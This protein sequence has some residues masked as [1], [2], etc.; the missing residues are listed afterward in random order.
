MT[1]RAGCR[2]PRPR[3]NKVRPEGRNN[4]K[5]A[6][7]SGS[8]VAGA[9]VVVAAALAGCGV[10]LTPVRSMHGPQETALADAQTLEQRIQVPPDAPVLV[11]VSS[12]DVDVKAAVIED[13][14][15]EPAY[16]DAPNRRMGVETL[17]VDAPHAPVVMVRIAR[18]DHSGARG[19]ITIEAVGLPLATDADRKRLAAARHD[20]DACR[21]FADLAQGEQAA[22]AYAEAAQSWGE[23]GDD[24]RQGFALLHASGARYQRQSDWS[25]SADLA[26]RAFARLESTES[27]AHAAFALR[28]QGAALDQLANAANYDVGRRERTAGRARELLSQAAARFEEL[29][30]TF[31]AGYALSYRGVSHGQAGDLPRS[32][33]DFRAAAERFRIAGDDPAQAVALQSLASLS[34][35]DGRSA[36]SVREFEA[37][38]ALIPRDED[39]ANYAHTLHNSAL[40]LRVLGRF[41]EAV[42][43]EHES[44]EMLRRLGDRDG[45]ARALHSLALV[46]MYTGESERAAELLR[47]AIR[48]RGETGVRREQAIALTNLAEI[49]RSSGR[50]EAALELD[51]QALELA[52]APHDRAR[53]LLS[54]A[55]DH[56]MSGARK[57]ARERL[58]SILGL[59]IAAAHRLRALALAELGSLEAQ[60]RN[61]AASERHFERAIA[62]QETGALDVDH[63]RT[64]TSRASA[65]LARADLEGALADATSALEKFDGV[66]VQSLHAEARAAFRAHYRDA[67]EL[68]IASLLAQSAARRADRPSEADGLLRAALE[69]SDGARAGLLAESAGSSPASVPADL[70][71]ERQ[72]VYQLLAGKRHQRD[73]L[74]DAAAADTDRADALAREIELLRAQARL[75][76]GRIARVTATGAGTRTRDFTALIA[77][78]PAEVLVAEFFIG[79]ERG[80]LFEVRQ[81]GIAVHPLGPVAELEDRARELHL[82]WRVAA[83]KPADRYAGARML[84]QR[85]FGPLGAAPAREVRIVPDGALH[86]VPMALLAQLAWPALPAGAAVVVPSLAAHDAA[87]A[88]D[89]RPPQTLAIIADPVYEAGDPRIR[90]APP[91]APGADD[92]APPAIGESGA[93]RR[94]PSTAIEARELEALVGDPEQT[95]SL[96]GPQASRD[97]VMRAPLDRFRL[98]HFATHALADGRDPALASIALSRF[99]ADGEPLD[100]ALRQYDITQLRLQA[101]LVVLS[102]CD[103]ALGREIAGEG[104]IGLSQAF[105]RSGARA[106]V[107]TLWQVPDTSTAVLMREFYRQMLE[108]GRAAPDA[109][110]LAQQH[111]RRQSR[112]SDPFYWAGFQLVSNGRP[113]LGNNNVTGREESQ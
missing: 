6:M 102:G 106:V 103:T 75:V 34:H 70:L 36:D 28:L 113:A 91:A 77:D 41:D 1:I 71:L 52:V 92:A 23:I 30:M 7:E 68:R 10:D 104:P 93:L 109:L 43:R 98:L 24:R 37:A 107:A 59:D 108:Q 65:R 90:A 112:W 21:A 18:N 29:G 19:A 25:S 62:I 83:S 2:T 5:K 87:P 60:D 14:A 31:E 86:L 17:L 32:R 85:L 33:E 35:E 64:L 27:P 39:P 97:N 20:A 54:L 51:R 72:Q 22:A 101:D 63:A 11:T 46:M 69:A 66:G 80:W 49:E 12:R 78:L 55:Q 73:R 56:A 96:I 4:D 13:D 79:R 61:D 47:A 53:V 94:L 50:V 88:R 8:R 45:E 81:G 48:L 42:A 9:L 58:Q 95:L 16:C 99:G 89:T 74:L 57:Q 100:G 26:A 40:P 110:A 105:L 67:V 111:L 82:S 76:E 84:S 3:D 44:A 38:L 15:P